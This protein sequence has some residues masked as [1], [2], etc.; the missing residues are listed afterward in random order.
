M[1]RSAQ[2]GD[3][4]SISGIYNEYIR[5]SAATFE[6]DDVP[7]D[8]MARRIETVLRDYPWLVF[9][10]HNE[11]VGYTYARR[12]RDRAAYRHT[13]ETGTYLDARFTGKGIGTQLKQALLDELKA[14][15]FH[16]VISGIALPNPASVALC[17]KF[18]FIK[19][20]HFSE[21]GRKFNRWIDVG[22][23]QLKL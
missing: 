22:Y 16:A 23:W 9:E 19:V 4:A 6:E 8:E 20:A 12:W 5:N 7:P 15:G 3:A 1:I 2:I 17:E 18:G 21:V 11:I 10:E 13:V 14:R